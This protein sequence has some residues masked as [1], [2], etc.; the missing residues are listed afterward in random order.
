MAMKMCGEWFE[1]FLAKLGCPEYKAEFHVK[2]M[3]GD[4]HEK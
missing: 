4:R 3:T 1:F 2:R